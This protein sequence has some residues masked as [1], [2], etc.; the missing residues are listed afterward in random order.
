M[1]RITHGLTTSHIPAVG[2]TIDHGRTQEPY[3][4]PLFDGYEWT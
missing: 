3:W 4:K 2:A 1:A